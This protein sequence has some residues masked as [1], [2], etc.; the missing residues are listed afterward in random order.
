MP[1]FPKKLDDD[2]V[3]KIRELGMKRKTIQEIAEELHLGWGT[4]AHAVRKYNIP[5]RRSRRSPNTP[6]WMDRIL[7]GDPESLFTDHRFVEEFFPS[8]AKRLNGQSR[9]MTEVP[10][11]GGEAL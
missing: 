2:C 7:S 6:I 10:A 1:G 3:D 11:E 9:H 8:T 4:V 5:H